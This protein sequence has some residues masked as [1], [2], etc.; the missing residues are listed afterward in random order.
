MIGPV[1]ARI[2]EL[3]S[4]CSQA[5]RDIDALI[6]LDHSLL[7]ERARLN[8][9]GSPS[10]VSA[11]GTCRLVRAEDGWI[12]VNLART[13]DHATL[14]AWIGMDEKAEDPWKAIE[15]R[16]Q[17][18]QVSV[19][20]EQGQLLGLPVAPAYLGVRPNDAQFRNEAVK[21]TR[22]TAGLCRRSR[23]PLVID[24][25]SL[26]AGPLCGHILALSGGDVVKIESSSR[27]DGARFGSTKFFDSLNQNKKQISIEFRSES[28]KAELWNWL[29]KADVVIESARP[30][31]LAQLGF[32]VVEIFA[33]NPFLTWVS[34]T[35][36]GRNGPWSNYVGFGDDA[37]AAGGLLTQSSDG[38]PQFI[39][40]AIA[41]PISGI[42]AASV[43]IKS[44]AQGGGV[45]L[46]VSLRQAAASVA[47][48]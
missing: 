3:L 18:H 32:D 11:N 9:F 35:A 44:M 5:A 36:Y 48:G 15:E 24:L 16:V 45:L 25:S 33:R 34:I 28:G 12:A 27:P 43:A 37:A 31:A 1:R 7:T 10:K 23:N 41:D 20:V 13:E 47:L 42:I 30:R 4:E 17:G 21:Q 39:G 14:P 46:D 19:L 6:E 2:E 40:D 22:M 8:G 26:W 29:E 38:S